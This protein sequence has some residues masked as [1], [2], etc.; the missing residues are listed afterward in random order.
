MHA[1]DLHLGST[2][3]GINKLPASL[4]KRVLD[5]SLA[6]FGKVIDFALAKQVDFI[7]LAGDVFEDQTPSL[8]V[9][10][11]FIEQLHRLGKSNI[12][13][14]MVT[15]NHDA[16][17]LENIVFPLPD[18]LYTFP[19]DRPSVYQRNINNTL[20]NIHGVS[21]AQA[22]V[23][24]NL[25]RLFPPVNQEG[26]N[27][28]IL[29]C[30]V[31]GG[32]ESRYAPVSIGELTN[33]G[34]DYWALGHV[35]NA[36]S[37][38]GANWHYPGVLQGRHLLEDDYKGFYF[39]EYRDEI[40]T[41]HFQAAQ[42]IRLLNSSLD[43]SQVQLSSLTESLLEHKEEIR[44]MDDVGVILQVALVGSSDLNNWLENRA[45]L[46]DLLD[47]L[48][49]GEDQLDN[50]VWVTQILNQTTPAIDYSQLKEQGDFLAEVLQFIDDLALEQNAESKAMKELWDPVVQ[51]SGS[52]LNREEV[53]AQVKLQATLLLRG[54]NE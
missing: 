3:S 22:E 42:D 12:E 2:V 18:N 26:F 47:Q 52:Q 29:H 16:R 21:Y 51:A 19:V 10:R 20:V 4:R 24:E 33:S 39:V 1:A 15:G 11:Y 34:Y 40:V 8:R 13:V 23:R 49:V 50:F 54:E 27:L 35:H 30:E 32:Q 9:Q 43:V 44:G 45:E 5:C 6:A 48:Q 36:F 38:S 53:L 17:V 14:F 7:V 31:G 41:S 46:A 28:G 37:N 25:F